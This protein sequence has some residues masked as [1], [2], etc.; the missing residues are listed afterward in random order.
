MPRPDEPR[1]V[2][3]AMRYRHCSSRRLVELR[4]AAVL[5]KDD[6]AVRLIDDEMPRAERDAQDDS[7]PMPHPVN[8]IVG[9]LSGVRI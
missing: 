2:T 4:A 7:A 5:A 6:L 8:L 3:L 9:M 1:D